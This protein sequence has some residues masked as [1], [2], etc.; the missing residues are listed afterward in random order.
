MIQFTLAYA[1]DPEMIE[2]RTGSLDTNLAAKPPLI[3]RRDQLQMTLLCLL[4]A[5]QAGSQPTPL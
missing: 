4:R 1:A 2:L 3:I 5:T